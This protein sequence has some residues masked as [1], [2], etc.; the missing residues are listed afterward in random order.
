MK[1]D[2]SKSYNKETSAR[3]SQFFSSLNFEFIVNLVI[4]RSVFDLTLSATQLLQS[5][6]NDISDGVNTI[7]AL[8][9]LV[10]E[11]RKN[12]D[13]RHKIWYQQALSLAASVN[14]SEHKQRSVKR[15]INRE[16]HEA[17]TISSYYLRTVSIPLVDHLLNELDSRFTDETL[18]SYTGLY[19]IPSKIV[20]MQSSSSSWKEKVKP[21]LDFYDDDFPN[22]KAFHA[23][24]DLWEKFWVTNK[25]LC[26]SNA[27]ATLKAVH[28]PGF[29]NIKVA[30]KI[31]ATL[32]ITS[33]ECERS[34]STMRRLKNYMRTTMGENRLNGLALMNVHSD[35]VPDPEKVINKFRVVILGLNREKNVNLTCLVSKEAQF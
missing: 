17:D 10:H 23:E 19:L 12:I 2:P 15:Q 27:I 9:M 25:S 6:T 29:E 13:E 5:T 31:L 1:L 21:F 24:L 22:P 11:I 7:K 4:T 8:I 28:Y 14:V 18:I 33:C 32:P 34:F 35:I 30:L 3:G 20:S 26:P 16:N